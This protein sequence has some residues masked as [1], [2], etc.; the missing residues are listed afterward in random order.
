MNP[1]RSPSWRHRAVRHC[2]LDRRAQ[3]GSTTHQREWSRLATRSQQFRAA[4][5]PALRA[6]RF[7]SAV[8]RRQAAHCAGISAASSAA[9]PSAATAG[10]TT[11]VSGA[12]P[13]S[14][15]GTG[16][17]A[18]PVPRPSRGAMIGTPPVARFS[19][20]GSAGMAPEPRPSR[21]AI[22]GTLPVAR[23]SRGE[24]QA[25]HSCC[26][27][28]AQRDW[29]H[30]PSTMDLVTV[31]GWRPLWREAESAAVGLAP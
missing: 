1:A 17:R 6:R 30:F 5:Q 21:G 16:T 9:G 2:R 28:H 8:V 25:R 4:T 15:I 14:P 22:M 18:L 12:L 24:S 3:Q 10:S 26:G 29:A 27:L 31:V 7:W 23:P 13:N 19:C 20:V 11:I